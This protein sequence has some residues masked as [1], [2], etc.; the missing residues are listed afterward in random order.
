MVRDT[1][2]REIPTALRHELYAIPSRRRRTR[3]SGTTD[4]QR[5]S[6][7]DRGPCCRSVG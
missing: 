7:A 3:R 5:A 4:V 1:P 2:L 6:I